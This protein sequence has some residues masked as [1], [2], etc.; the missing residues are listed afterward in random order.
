VGR[1]AG[2]I[3]LLVAVVDDGDDKQR[4]AHLPG[5]NYRGFHTAHGISTGHKFAGGKRRLQCKN[6]IELAHRGLE[7]SAFT[8]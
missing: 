4:Q 8:S 5:T 6:R 3:W 2:I 1:S 7:I